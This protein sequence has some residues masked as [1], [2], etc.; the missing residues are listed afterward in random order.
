MSEAANSVLSGLSLDRLLSGDVLAVQIAILIV[1]SLALAMSLALAI[2]AAGEARKATRARREAESHLRSAQDI[3]VEARQ[4]SAQIDRAVA[5]SAS[6]DSAGAV[7]VGARAETPL[8][9]VDIVKAKAS[10]NL[11][12]AAQ[13]A[14]VPHGL[15]GPRRR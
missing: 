10:R 13:S 12:A 5:R 15:L 14:A 3:V 6:A 2:M 8:A 1:T 4:L 9:D 11:D 7:R